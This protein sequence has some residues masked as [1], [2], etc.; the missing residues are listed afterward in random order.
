MSTNH[1]IVHLTSVHPRFDTRIFIK[2][3]SSLAQQNYDV[4]LIVADGKG[5]ELKN[6]VNIHDVGKLNGR[7][8]RIFKTTQNVYK[9]ALKLD[10]DLYHLHDPELIPIGLKLKKQG[11]KVI[12]DA[13]EDLPKQ[14]LGK[15]YLHPL[16]RK[17][18]STTARIYENFFCK[19][20][21]AIVAAT[22][23]IRDKFLI[24]NPNSV[25]INNYPILEELITSDVSWEKKQLAVCYVGGLSEIRGI[26]ELVE[27]ISITK[28]G[29]ILKLGGKFD[30]QTFEQLVKSSNG[31]PK[32]EKLG[33]L[34]RT[35]VAQ[36]YANSRAGLVTLRPAINYLDSLPVK[37]FE[38]MSAGIP[39]I[40]S[41]FTLWKEIIEGNHCGICVDPLSPRD[42]AQAIDYLILNP[43][44][45]EAMGRNGQ[46]IIRA[47]YNWGIEEQ[48]LL[49]LY[50]ELLGNKE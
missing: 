44:E 3:C 17:I 24:I 35:Q 39:V 12:F 22:P 28:T 26:L 37:M 49:T 4:S 43:K 48:K 38:Y 5:D 45:S 50:R 10:A 1:K 8:N 42:I 11:K 32:I 47:K 30:N 13:H 23:Y 31:S 14:L 27:A 21:D 33:W 25:D 34:N 15:P 40:A 18:L 46:K 41:N 20:F 6:S 19:R 16:A 36:T 2:I 29:T 7:I 9:K